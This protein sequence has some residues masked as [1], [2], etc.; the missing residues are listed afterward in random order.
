MPRG[1]GFQVSVGTE[2]CCAS[3]SPPVC[4]L[5]RLLFLYFEVV[6]FFHSFALLYFSSYFRLLSRSLW[7]LVFH[8]ISEVPK[9]RK[10]YR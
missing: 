1:E 3:A 10:S 9:H 6:V 5:I 4:S 8:I 2:S 7:P